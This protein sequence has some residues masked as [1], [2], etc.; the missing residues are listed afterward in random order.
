GAI[1]KITDVND[2]TVALVDLEDKANRDSR[3]GLFNH[4][5]ARRLIN[6]R[7]SETKGKRYALAF[8]DVDDFKQAN[9]RYGHLFGD[10]VLEAVAA[11]IK[12]N[13]RSTDIGA[14]MGG[15]EFIIFME[16]TKNLHAQIDRIFR[17]LTVDYKDY[18]LGVSM[19]VACTENFEGDYDELFRMADM[20]QY[21]VKRGNK[22][23]YCF[24]DES[25][26][27]VLPPADKR[28]TIR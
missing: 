14:R 12:E 26:K 1:G 15:D 7:L 28:E 27:S 8:F 9:D 3:T 22:C 2:E 6:E 13:I 10:E 20:A 5:A 19:G 23:N 16:Y 18:H 24:Y 25:M 17:R 4:N 21:T 11:R